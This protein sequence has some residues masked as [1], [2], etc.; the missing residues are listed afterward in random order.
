MRAA[1]FTAAAMVGTGIFLVAA[2]M[3]DLGGAAAGLGS[4]AIVGL[5][6]VVYVI[7]DS[8]L[9]QATG[10]DQAFDL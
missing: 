1:I 3:L 2:A 9:P 10:P 4:L 8:S 6:A 7:G 5:A